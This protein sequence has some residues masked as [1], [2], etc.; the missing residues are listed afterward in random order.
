MALVNFISMTWIILSSLFIVV[1]FSA[2]QGYFYDIIQNCLFLINFIPISEFIFFSGSNVWR[3]F[4]KKY[5]SVAWSFVCNVFCIK[6]LVPYISV[7][8]IT[9]LYIWSFVPISVFLSSHS[10]IIFTANFLHI[11]LLTPWNYN[12][13]RA[14]A[15]FQEELL[16]L[17]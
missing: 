5:I 3:T 16:H 4:K 14:M 9:D 12:P 10:F 6:G 17:V 11:F 7:L 8:W 13:S 2:H 15:A 1:Q